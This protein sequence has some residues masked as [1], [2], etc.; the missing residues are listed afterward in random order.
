[1]V[2]TVIPEG[3]HEGVMGSERD[4]GC[5]GRFRTCSGRSRNLEGILS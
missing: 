2:E 5:G 4:E 1:M 3:I